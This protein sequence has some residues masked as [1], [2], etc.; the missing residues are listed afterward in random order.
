[1]YNFEAGGEMT[2]ERRLFDDSMG[3]DRGA[4]AVD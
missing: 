2:Q 1:V 3:A 4:V